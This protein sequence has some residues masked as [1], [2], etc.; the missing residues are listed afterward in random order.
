MI[1][2]R[3][4]VV[5]DDEQDLKTS[6]DSITRYMDQ[7]QRVF[8]VIECKTVE[9]AFVKLDNSF[10]GAII[11][12][13]LDDQADAGNAVITRIVDSQF[14][15][16]IAI[17]TGT[18]DTADAAFSYIG[19]FKKGETEYDKLL[20]TFWGI[21]RS[22]LTRIMGGRGIIEKT[23]NT[24][25]MKNLLPQKDTWVAYGEQDATRAEKGL[26]RHTLNH[27]LQ[28]LDDDEDSKCFP[29]ELY[30]HPPLAQGLK[31]GSI[32]KK[33]DENTFFVVLNPPCDLVVRNNGTFKTDRILLAEV[34][35]D[36]ILGELRGIQ[37]SKNK[38]ERKKIEKCEHHNP[39][40]ECYKNTILRQEE[41]LDRSVSGLLKNTHDL[42]HHW[43]PKTDFFKGGF[44][45]FRKLKT[46]SKEEFDQLFSTPEIQIAPTFISD[47]LAR[48]SSY[49]GR[50]GQ[51]DIDF[52]NIISATA[53]AAQ[54]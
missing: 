41:A 15:I 17:L 12:L 30:I 13:R 23:L 54:G 52:T 26:L 11:D 3:L 4:M 29:V 5:E 37:N 51:P 36:S 28:I 46:L 38:S 16:P 34:D 48:F 33:K 50:Q 49:Y 31:T 39:E 6:R 47:I 2:F 53:G 42:Y 1:S 10:D 18:P 32:V 21:H 43:L 45:N 20:D 40:S 25:F 9:E 22:G 44:L 8:E 14:R 27:L 7:K 35:D 19:V 24:V